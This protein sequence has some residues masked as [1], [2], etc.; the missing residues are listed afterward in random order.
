MRETG[1]KLFGFGVV[2]PFVCCL[3]IC[4]RV[5]AGQQQAHAPHTTVKAM[6]MTR[7][8]SIDGDLSEEVWAQAEPATNFT[9]RD[10]DE[11]KP[12]TERT[13]VRVLYD[14]EALYIG[15]RMFD[16][17]ATHIARR[18]SSRDADQDADRLTIY[19]DPLHDHFTGVQ[20]HISAAGVQR[21]SIIS[22]DTWED[23][24]WDAV[25]HS[26]VSVDGAGWSA[27]LRIPFSQLRFPAGDRQTWGINISRYIRRRNEEAWLA[28]VPKNENGLASRMAHLTGLDG[29]VP[30][31]HFALLPYTAARADFIAP[32]RAGDPFNDG[33]RA[34]GAAGLDVK[35]G[36]TS[37]LTLD[38]TINP[39]FGQVE[40]DPAVVNL[41]AFETFFPE[42]RPFFIEGAQIFNN[43][44]QG[45]S[46]NFFGFNTSDPQVFYSRRIGRSPQG[47]ASADFLDQP[48]ATTILGAVKL[49]GKTPGGWSIGALDALTDR[50][51]AHVASG[52]ARSRV[53]VE[54]RTNYFV[55]RLQRDFGQR[56]SLG[57]L[58]TAVVRNLNT[59]LLQDA[60][61]RRA[62]VLGGDGHL[63]LDTARDWVITGKLSASRI[64]GTEAM[65]ARAQEA[66]QRYYQ[67]PD[68]S[69]VSFNPARRSLSGFAGRVNLNRNSGTW[70]VNAALWGVSP[71]FESNDL[72]FHSTGD[73]A[74]GHGVLLWRKTLPD[75][76]TRYRHV[77]VAKAWTWN[78]NR[79]LQTDGWFL[80]ANATF[81]NYWNVYGNLGLL[82]RVQDD[83]L[84]RGGPSAVNPGSRFLN[85]NFNSDPRKA[86]SIAADAGH[87]WTDAGG[88]DISSG[89]SV[90]LKPSSSLTIS[91]GPQWNR[92]R[93]MAQYIRSL[94]DATAGETYGGRYVFGV[95]D[96]TQLTMTTRVNVILSPQVSIQVFA[97]PL[98]A[99]G[100]Y[101]NFR[102]LARARTFEFLEYG[103]PGTRFS[104]DAS[105]RTYL[106]D[107]DDAGPASS[108]TFGDPDFN[109]KSLRVN[110]VLRWELKPGSTF[111]AVWTR[112]QQD[113]AHPGHFRFGRDAAA[114]FSAPS[115]DV[116]LIKMAYWLGR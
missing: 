57:M 77:F 103:S 9:Q 112:Q 111:Y 38:G 84:T 40:V 76:L 85:V 8:P 3:A 48:A 115:D 44:G 35:W 74:G 71:G 39:D 50:E 63:F 69:H 25:W 14:E 33:S 2:L 4:A 81:L 30:K 73:R 26:A 5:D 95:I 49:T 20:F 107:P 83:R 21:D 56:A 62:F 18:L 104:Y 6:R 105:S 99:V 75:R 80:S 106:V 64:T 91:T 100:D 1:S 110:A 61:A 70:Q 31:R 27:E 32:S 59:P 55:G 51:T 79:A 54:P 93:S 22:N 37:S 10:P 82:R 42:K 34:F 92:S 45:G 67:R 78:F 11:G 46:N 86:V 116:F 53:E 15:A 47:Q 68:A 87:G 88:W 60:L 17:D 29:I 58:T 97:Q 102:E 7:A 94:S 109:F 36:L 28:L 23:S 19:L 113:L 72:G 98:V 43:F 12:A 96:Q 108:F 65:L 52:E 101:A 114:L 41:T 13:D 24:S 89:V 90:S 16:R 66:P